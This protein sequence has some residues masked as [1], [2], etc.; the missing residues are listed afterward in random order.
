MSGDWHVGQEVYASHVHY[1][2]QAVTKVVKVGKTS[3]VCE[4]GS[5]W[6]LSGRPW[7]AGSTPWNSTWL[8]ELTP[9]RKAGIEAEVRVRNARQAI[10]R[11]FEGTKKI[12]A[13]DVLER[14]AA[15]MSEALGEE[16]KG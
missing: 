2:V 1:G 15:V 8:R 5:R 6:S 9:A 4:D 11:L 7:G 10:L 3:I 12:E 14:V 16:N 13:P